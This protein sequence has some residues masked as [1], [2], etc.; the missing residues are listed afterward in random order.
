MEADFASKQSFCS[1]LNYFSDLQDLRTNAPKIED[2]AKLTKQYV[3]YLIYIFLF[4]LQNMDFLKSLSFFV[5][6]FV[7]ISPN[8]DY[9][10]SAYIL[11]C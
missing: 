2:F 9:H 1:V 5:L 6:T 11:I 4:H 7:R 3:S 10:K 8:L